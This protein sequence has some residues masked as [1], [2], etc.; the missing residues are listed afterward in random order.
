MTNTQIALLVLVVAVLA[1]YLLKRRARQ[2][3][4]D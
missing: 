2:N 1:L 3:K 4:E